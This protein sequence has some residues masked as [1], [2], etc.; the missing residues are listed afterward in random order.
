MCNNYGII[1]KLTIIH[2][3][4]AN[5]IIERVHKVVNKILRS[6]DLGKENSEDANPFD[7]L[8]QS[9]TWAMRC[10]YHTKLQATPCHLVFGRDMI[11]IV[12]F[13]ANWNRIQKRKQD[14]INKYNN[15]E[16]KR[17]VPYKYKVRHQVLLEMPGILRKLSTLRTGLYAVTKVYKHGTM[18]FQRGI[19]T[20]L[21]LY[22]FDKCSKSCKLKYLDNMT[23][24]MYRN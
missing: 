15:K 2:N 4:Q 16:N 13:Q 19:E 9:T 7:Y 21:N 3:P 22:V 1:A 12:A 11:D 10:T 6:F 18:Q 8:L 20:T 23:T 17:C 14:L 5:A 24:K